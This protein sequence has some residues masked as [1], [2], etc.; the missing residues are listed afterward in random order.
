MAKVLFFKPTSP[1][2]STIRSRLGVEQDPMN[3]GGR[4]RPAR[5]RYCRKRASTRRTVIGVG[6]SAQMWNTLPVDKNGKPL[7]PML[8]WLDLRSVRQ[9]DRVLSGEMPAFIFK[10]TAIFRLPRIAFQDLM[11][12]GRAS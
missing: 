4:W 3:S 5:A 8:S 10:H 11:V 7:T 9:A 6:V 2:G 1:T 12:E